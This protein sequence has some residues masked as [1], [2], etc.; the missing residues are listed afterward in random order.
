MRTY[1][2]EQKQLISQ[3]LE[4]VFGLLG[5]LVH[6]LV[7]RRQSTGIFDSRNEAVPCTFKERGAAPAVEMPEVIK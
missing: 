2:L 7:V 6:A 3:R 5:N 4:E 1:L